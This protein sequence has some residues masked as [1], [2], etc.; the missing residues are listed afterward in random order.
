M[1]LG[2][3]PQLLELLT[4]IPDFGAIGTARMHNQLS[5]GRVI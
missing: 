1:L 4:C 2:I 3:I 5:G